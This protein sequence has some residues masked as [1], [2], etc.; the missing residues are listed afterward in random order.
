MHTL[1]SRVTVSCKLG[2]IEIVALFGVECTDIDHAAPPGLLGADIFEL[3][4]EVSDAT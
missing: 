1:L 4:H 3:A 2:K